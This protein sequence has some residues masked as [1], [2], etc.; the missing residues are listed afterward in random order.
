MQVTFSNKPLVVNVRDLMILIIFIHL[1]L[2]IV[3]EFLANEF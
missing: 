3:K 1:K 2:T